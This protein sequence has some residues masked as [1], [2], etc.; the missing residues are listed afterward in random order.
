MLIHGCID[1]SGAVI[2]LGNTT[3]MDLIVLNLIETGAS[4][5]F[6]FSWQNSNELKET[7][8]SRMYSTTFSKWKDE[9]VEIYKRTNEVLSQ[10]NGAFITDHK[11]DGEV[12][13]TTY[14]NG[15]KI[16]VNKGAEDSTI[17][18]VTVPARDYYVGR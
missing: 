1:Y 10:V 7:G 2:N 5:H 6:K 9:S 16:Y 15:V 17:D 14:S 18:G 3:D 12:S 13:V 8:I 4:P 11:A